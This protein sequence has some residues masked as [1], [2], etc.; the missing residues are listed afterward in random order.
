MN[1]LHIQLWQ[2]RS[3]HSLWVLLHE[4]LLLSDDVGELLVTKDNISYFLGSD[5][6]PCRKA[7]ITWSAAPQKLLAT[8]LYVVGLLPSAVEVKSV[9]RMAAA[10]AEQVGP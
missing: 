10:T 8:A 3:F 9:S 1:A 7:T 5:G 6:K 4:L 2:V